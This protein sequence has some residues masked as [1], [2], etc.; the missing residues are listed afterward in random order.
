MGSRAAAIVLFLTVCITGPSVWALPQAGVAGGEIAQRRLLHLRHG[1]NVSKWFAGLPDATAY[2]KE[3]FETAITAQDVELIRAMGFDYVRLS[4]DPRPMFH[5]KQADQID[6]EYLS[7]LDSAVRMLLDQ[8]LAVDIDIYADPDFKERL[9]SDDESVEEFADFWRALARHWSGLDPDRV[10]FEILNEP[11]GKDRY[12]WYG[13]EAKLATAI[14]EGAPRHT[15]VATGAHWSDDDDLVFLEPLRDGN[16]IYT[17]HFYEPHVFTHQG[18]TWSTNYWRSLK[19]VPY[20]STPEN[21]QA[22]MEQV[23]DPV[24]RLAIERY[25]MDHW[26]AQRIEGEVG[27]VAAWASHWNVPVICNEF[28][29]YRKTADPAQRAAWISDVRTSLEKHGIGWAMWD[30]DGG[31]DVVNRQDGKAVPDLATIRALG[32]TMPNSPN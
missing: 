19:G 26:N 24:H 9:A 31:F 20:P 18:A 2:T 25:G 6:S 21:V 8:G 13:V 28:G 3:H 14:R 27:Q 15:I 7:E 16:V 10:F 12:R 11:G 29:V 5:E 30:Y 4:V 32:F 1:I 22:V 23:T 17:F